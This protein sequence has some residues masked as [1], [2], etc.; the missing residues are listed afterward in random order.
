MEAL[1]KCALGKNYELTIKSILI[2]KISKKNSHAYRGIPEVQC[3]I[4]TALTPKSPVAF[5]T[6]LQASFLCSRHADCLSL[7]IWRSQSGIIFQISRHGYFA[8]KPQEPLCQMSQCHYNQSLCQHLWK[9]IIIK[10]TSAHTHTHTHTHT[11]THT[12]LHTVTEKYG[13]EMKP[14]KVKHE[15]HLEVRWLI[16]WFNASLHMVWKTAHMH[17]SFYKMEGYLTIHDTITHKKNSYVSDTYGK[18]IKNLENIEKSWCD[19]K[20]VI[21]REICGFFIRCC[22]VYYFF[23]C[24]R[25]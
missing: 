9:K 22:C 4:C 18:G 12:L 1:N 24:T 7:I 15:R 23:V 10:Q 16:Y 6:G 8:S 11:D 14:I 25:R 17:R 5:I 20:T 2:C 19:K 21:S 3:G 13:W